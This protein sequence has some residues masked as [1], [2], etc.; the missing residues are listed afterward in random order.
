MKRNTNYNHERYGQQYYIIKPNKYIVSYE[1][2]NRPLIELRIIKDSYILKL[3]SDNR[4]KI[5]N[6]LD[7]LSEVENEIKKIN[8]KVRL[9]YTLSELNLARLYSRLKIYYK[10]EINLEDDYIINNGFI[11]CNE[12]ISY[13]DIIKNCESYNYICNGKSCNGLSSA[14][15]YN[16]KLKSILNYNGLLINDLESIDKSYNYDNNVNWIC[17]NY[18][19]SEEECVNNFIESYK[20]YKFDLYIGDDH[21]EDNILKLKN[22]DLMYNQIKI[23]LN[24]IKENGIMICR[25]Y[26]E[27]NKKCVSTLYSLYKLFKSVYLFRPMSSKFENL[28]LYIICIGLKS[29]LKRDIKMI[30]E[31]DLRFYTLLEMYLKNVYEDRYNIIKDT[32][33]IINRYKRSDIEKNILKRILYPLREYKKKEYLK[34]FN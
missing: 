21:E 6:I 16:L 4:S 9:N 31:I 34:L 30:D 33:L 24:I 22:T 1:K 15:E 8:K 23:G 12:I 18:N 26:P 19:L 14:L 7:D 29:D 10:Y 3:E 11:K 25:I 20:N 13:F 27:F 5:I 28:E 32:L 17:E 2:F